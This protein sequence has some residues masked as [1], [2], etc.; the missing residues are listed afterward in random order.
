MET[1]T[2]LNAEETIGLIEKEFGW[3][4]KERC[5]WMCGDTDC[6]FLDEIGDTIYEIT[7]S[8][9]TPEEAIAKLLLLCP[10]GTYHDCFPWANGCDEIF[11]DIALDLW[12]MI[13]T[14]RL[15]E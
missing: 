3:R 11:C 4:W 6:G 14:G 7:E 15:P 5:D 8:K 9:S 2:A 1:T 12:T 10:D 13:H